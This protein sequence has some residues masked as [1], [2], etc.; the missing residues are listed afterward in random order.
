MSVP[1]SN[2]IPLEL[3]LDSS[4]KLTEMDMHDAAGLAREGCMV[5][6]RVLPSEAVLAFREAFL[7]RVGS[8]VEVQ[9]HGYPGHAAH[10]MVRERRFLELVE[11]PEIAQLA[12]GLLGEPVHRIR[13]T[14]LRHFVRGTHVASRAH[15]DGTYLGWG[16]DR[17]LTFWIPL[18]HCPLESGPLVYLERSH[19]LDLQTVRAA[20]GGVSDRPGDQ[21]PITHELA[22]LGRAVARRWLWA[23]LRAGDLIV[24]VPGI[25][26]ASLDCGSDYSRLS[27][28]VRYQ[29]A[30]DS[31]DPRWTKDWSGDDSY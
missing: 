16:S 8:D 31:V 6:R 11:R 28:D 2:G 9:S 3:G 18:G 4:G 13:R 27:T 14:P 5:V 22:R 29:P 21:R 23:D 30:G 24:H 17:V 12:S 7:A 10:A 20:V 1:T 26:H 19:E 15:L 25:I